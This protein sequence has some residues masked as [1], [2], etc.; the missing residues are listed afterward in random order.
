MHL[1][2]RSE[3]PVISHEQAFLSS[4]PSASDSRCLAESCR[5][6]PLAEPPPEAS[7]SV[8][9][10]YF[11]PEVREGRLRPAQRPAGEVL[12]LF[13]FRHS[14]AESWME[15]WEIG[16]LIMNYCSCTRGLPK[17]LTTSSASR[18]ATRF[19]IASSILSRR[20]VALLAIKC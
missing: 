4:I 9:R 12:T 13:R 6:I 3:K 7:S 5:Q 18:P 2:G 11:L 20:A 17:A 10:K 19:P 15:K 14:P 8:A 1:S 16:Q